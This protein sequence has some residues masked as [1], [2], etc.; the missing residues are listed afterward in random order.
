[1]SVQVDLFGN[2]DIR[3]DA[4]VST[5]GLYRYHLART[6]N[7]GDGT[8]T[9]IMLN[10]S[11]ADADRDD[12]TIKK[13]IKFARAWGYGAIM[14][15][16]LY[17]FRATDPKEMLAAADPVGPENDKFL[18]HMALTAAR[19][20]ELLVGAWGANARS[21]R[22]AAVR[23]LPGMHRLLALSLTKSGQPGHPLF[24]P[25]GSYPAFALPDCQP[26]PDA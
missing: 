3:K 16:N 15:G 21:D 19:K 18:T 14:V 6:W 13:C 5:D 20:G 10:P 17:A 23:A 25:S 8:V 9:F 1:M 22:V 12:P 11:T 7:K 26:V 2:V 24:L 4:L